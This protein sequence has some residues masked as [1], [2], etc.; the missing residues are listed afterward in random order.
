MI[1]LLL[2][3][4]PIVPLAKADAFVEIH[5]RHAADRRL[6]FVLNHNP[7]QASV[8]G[9]PNGIDLISSQPSKGQL[10]LPAYGVAIVEQSPA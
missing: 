9:L 5:C 6:F 7:K 10:T 1:S 3:Q 8:T 2:D 4:C